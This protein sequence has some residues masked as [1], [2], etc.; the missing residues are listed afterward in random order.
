MGTRPCQHPVSGIQHPVSGTQ[1]NQQTP[2]TK[3]RQKK[4]SDDL[5]GVIFPK[6]SVVTGLKIAQFKSK[7]INAV[8]TPR[9]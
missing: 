5:N 7:F 1:S 4:Q 9:T 6:R 3:H 8:L 2:N